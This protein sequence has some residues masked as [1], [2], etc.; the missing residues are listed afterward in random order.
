MPL[1]ETLD[2]APRDSVLAETLRL[3][4]PAT[5]GMLSQWVVNLADI[6][7]VGRLAHGATADRGAASIANVH[8]GTIYIL[9][10]LFT[11][12]AL[13]IGT[14]AVAARRW[15]ER[16]RAAAER[17]MTSGLILAMALSAVL[18]PLYQL[19]AP[20]IVETF[21]PSGEVLDTG[22]VTGYLRM[23]FWAI[24]AMLALFVM[25]GWFNGVGNTAVVMVS[26]LFVN[27]LNIL[28]NWCWIEGHWGFPRLEVQGAALASTVATWMGVAFLVIYALRARRCV[29]LRLLR[30]WRVD[31]VQLMRIARLSFPSFIHL[32]ALHTG[33][34]VFHGLIIPRTAEGT[35]AVAASGIAWNTAGLCFFV[36]YGFGIAAAT[37]LGQGLGAGTLQRARQCV[38]TACFLGYGV[39]LLLAAVYVVFGRRIA[40][41]F[42]A[43]PEVIRLTFWLFVIVASFQILDNFGIILSEAFKGAGMTLFVMLIEV[44]VNLLFLIIAWF[45]G[46][47]LDL[48]VIGAWMGMIVYAIIFALVMIVS[49]RRGLWQHARA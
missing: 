36:S 11:F 12:G 1:P 26:A 20:W 24:P 35:V 9:A 23:R 6:H 48:G 34:L 28:L 45:L 10:M 15:G 7:M 47:H 43:D 31:R 32:G 5:L 39:N 4:L 14:Q 38:W 18:L 27:A 2:P 17:A 3:G 42:N 49:F 46:V 44:P 21:S 25:R 41:L 19:I 22:V 33:F 8:V 30:R 37:M 40:S 29:E 13:A 16:D